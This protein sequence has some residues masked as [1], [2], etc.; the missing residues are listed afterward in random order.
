MRVLDWMNTLRVIFFSHSPILPISQTPSSLDLTGT[1]FE[2][3]VDTSRVG[4]TGVS[5]G[6]MHSWL[7]A[8]ADT[9]VT[10]TCPAIGVQVAMTLTLTLSNTSHISCTSHAHVPYLPRI[11]HMSPAHLP[12]ISH[13]S[14]T[15]LPHISHTCPHSTLGGRSRMTRGRRGWWHLGSSSSSRQSHRTLRSMRN[16]SSRFRPLPSLNPHPIPSPLPLT[17]TSLTPLSP[18]PP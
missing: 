11:S 3:F 4:A 12:R 2:Q 1:F 15:H 6:G 7:W 18:P 10:S 8:A 14:P 17:R 5:L 9:R 13:T 16:G